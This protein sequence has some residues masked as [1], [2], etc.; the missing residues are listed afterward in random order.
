M[1]NYMILDK[2][3]ENDVN[4][5]ESKKFEIIKDKMSSSLQCDDDDTG[6][7]IADDTGTP[8]ADDTGTPIAD[9]TG[10]P[11][12][13]DTGTP[14]ADDT[15]TPIADDTETPIAD[16]TGTP[17]AD[18]TGTPIADDTETP[19]A[20]DTG[21]PIADD[22][23]YGNNSL[24]KYHLI[25]KYKISFKPL[26]ET[27]PESLFDTNSFDPYFFI[28]DATYISDDEYNSGRDIIYTYEMENENDLDEV[29]DECL[30]DKCSHKEMV[31]IS[32]NEVQNINNNITFLKKMI[33]DKE[34]EIK[35]LKNNNKSL[36]EH[37]VL[38][39]NENSLFR[40]QGDILENEN[41]S[42]VV[43]N[44]ILTKENDIL[45]KDNN[46]LVETI[47]KSSKKISSFK[48]IV[49]KYKNDYDEL[50]NENTLLR[51]KIDHYLDNC[52]DLYHKNMRLKLKLKSYRYS[53]LTN[54]SYDDNPDGYKTV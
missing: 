34:C 24:N 41:K 47:E 9:D 49:N 13:D 15:G 16:D 46:I 32:M 42:I 2:N 31:F 7:P 38:L 27:I 20:D 45:I 50:Y 54:N 17:I 8:I 30:E 44:D 12:A 4:I 53:E 33:N 5:D 21:T 11:I 37:N 3:Q 18:D 36:K 6:T 22:T 1:G 52:D 19:I 28:D 25:D 26:L 14:I 10:T 48:N 23:K 39:M 40:S 35:Q 43:H 29:S 51:K